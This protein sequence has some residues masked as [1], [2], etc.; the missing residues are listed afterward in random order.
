MSESSK[1]QV[2]PAMKK[3]LS[4]DAEI[5]KR[6]VLWANQ[7]LPL[8]SLRI[9]YKALEIT[10]HGIPWFAFWIAFT[11]LFNNPSLVQLQVNMLMGLLIDIILIAVAKA[12]FRRRRPM[13]NTDDALGQIGP[14]VFSFPSGHASRAV[15][16]AYFFI[17]LWPLPI[18]CIPPLLAWVTAICLSRILMNRHYILDVIGGIVF[19]LVVSWTVC[20]IW[21]DKDAASY[22]MSF[23]SD[24]KIDGGDYHV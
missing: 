6:F 2:P 1:R 4:L 16:V 8:R 12:Y 21:L 24:D 7:F 10:C 11:W 18:F 5:T 19:G 23:L 13:A 3:L 17:N 15:F 14:D 20:L 9:H 22:L